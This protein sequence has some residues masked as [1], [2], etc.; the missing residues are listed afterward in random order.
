MKFTLRV[1]VNVGLALLLVACAK[2]AKHAEIETLEAIST[3][4]TRP[5]GTV[6]EATPSGA[7]L[8]ETKRIHEAMRIID[9]KYPPPDVPDP[10]STVYR[11][12]GMS[13]EGIV[14]LV[15]GIQVRLDGVSCSEEGVSKLSRMMLDPEAAVAFAPSSPSNVQPVAAQVWLVRYLDVGAA[16]P[17][18][19]YIRVAESAL[20]S[21]WCTPS[22]TG[23]SMGYD[24]RYA[25]IAAVAAEKSRPVVQ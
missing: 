18:P 7:Q 13:T 14:H 20:L 25:A 16:K 12:A 1:V 23:T 17:V 11:V 4:E 24:G 10:Q 6:V 5:G 9:D 19:S 15:G 21:G 3:V 8:A 22:K 2:H